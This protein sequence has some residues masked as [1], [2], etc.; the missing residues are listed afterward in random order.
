MHGPVYSEFTVSHP[1]GAGR[2]S[3]R[4]RLTH[5]VR[6]IDIETTLLNK[7]MHVRYQVLFATAIKGGKNVQ[8]VAYGAIERPMGVEFPANNWVDYGNGDRGVGLLNAAMP[9][10]LVTDGTMML[11]LLRSVNLGDYN[12]GDSSDTGFELDTPRTLRYS[13]VPHAGD[14]RQARLAQAGQEFNSPLLAF[15]AEPHKGA[16]PST[17]GLLQIAEPNVVVT[18]VRP[19][20]DHTLIVRLYESWGKAMD[21]VAV[22][23]NAKVAGADEANL[24]EDTTGRLQ[25]KGNAVMIDL[26]PFEIKTL[27]LRV[28]G[29]Q[30]K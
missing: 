16:L 11:S 14:W 4:I 18:S 5:G 20:P 3:T 28:A 10:N 23:I 8:E 24:L 25:V 1:F 13:L 17:W 26:H 22:R 6:R 19:G 12:G 9:G 15:K 7:D 2:F 21:G 27:K 30:N 29:V